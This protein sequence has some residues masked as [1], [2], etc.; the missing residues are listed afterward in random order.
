MSGL[1]TSH[2]RAVRQA[3][4]A[5]GSI[6]IPE[7]QIAKQF[8]T[9]MI[10][11]GGGWFTNKKRV[12]ALVSECLMESAYFRTTVEYANTGPYQPY[13]GRTFIQITW[14]TNYAEFGAWCKKHGL[15]VDA[16]YFV[17]NPVE[18]G[19]AEWAALGG[20][21]YF[22]EKT[23]NGK[24]LCQIADGGS[25]LQIG[26]AVNLGN[27]YSSATPNGQSARDKAWRLVMSLP[28]DIVPA[29]VSGKTATAGKKAKTG[30]NGEHLYVMYVTKNGTKGW[31]SKKTGVVKHTRKRGF[32]VRGY[33][34]R[35]GKDGRYLRTLYG[36]DYA[37]DNGTLSHSKPKK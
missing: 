4:G 32:K 20:V 14:K 5:S 16:D 26:R 29:Q 3:A 19:R 31:A 36:T 1:T 23:W 6:V 11:Y 15:V 22:T 12:A 28:N 10:K 8:N 2:I 13:R 30:P 9:A 21:W 27:P 18:L 34:V 7:A 33:V 37:L 24:N 17:K 35:R 25:S